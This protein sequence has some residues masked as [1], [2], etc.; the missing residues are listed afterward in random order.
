MNTNPWKLPAQLTLPNAAG[1]AV[2]CLVR[3][4][5]VKYMV[6]LNT[7]RHWLSIILLCITPN[8]AHATP[9]LLAI[10][11]YMPAV[12][13]IPRKDVEITVRFWVEEIASK[14]GV[15]IKPVQL[16]DDLSELKR[17][18][19]SGKVNYIVGTPMGLAQQFSDDDLAGGFTGAGAA[20][21][22]LMLV[23][24]RDSG[25][26][27][28]GDLAGRHVQLRERDELS[29]IY[30]NTLL[31]SSGISPSQLKVVSTQKN[32][33]SLVLKLFFDQ[34]D[35]ALITRNAFELAAELNPQIRKRL[36][37]LDAY[38]FDAYRDN[39]ALFSSSV[40]TEDREAMIAAALKVENTP[41]GR[42]LLEIYRTDRL[43][44]SNVSDLHPYRDLLSTHNKLATN[45][46]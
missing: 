12:R 18:V 38:T 10:G 37:V 28:P 46:R 6:R 25:I 39:I 15:S 41:R 29:E 20:N 3:F 14:A 26:K 13:D 24:R 17:D 43:I 23:V 16:Y 34:C 45:G 42:Q 8:L 11:V 36:Q 5:K 9:P 32:A 33:N 4:A 30:L 40:S 31:R 7:C 22:A 19:D 1:G 44:L 27:S 21:D 35:A 2:K